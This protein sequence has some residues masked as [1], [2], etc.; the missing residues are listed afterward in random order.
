MNMQDGSH[1]ELND[2]TPDLDDTGAA[3]DVEESPEVRKWLS[4]HGNE[5]TQG[6]EALRRISALE[7][8]NQQLLSLAQ[9][10][11]QEVTPSP[12]RDGLYNQLDAA[13]RQQWDDLLRST[14]L[15]QLSPELQ[16][17]K[18]EVAEGRQFREQVTQ[19]FQQQ[20]QTALEGHVASLRQELGDD[21]DEGMERDIRNA[22]TN[23]GVDVGNRMVELAKQIASGKQ[24][25]RTQ[26]RNSAASF[27][28]TPTRGGRAIPN[29]LKKQSDGTMKYD[30]KQAWEDAERLAAQNRGR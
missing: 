8:Q 19:Y 15:E 29:G 28:G 13:Q 16:Q 11:R 7:Q 21:F 4:K 20:G 5:L 6:R 27:G 17:L 26:Q 24:Q 3:Q 10:N 25:T 18:K 1:E 2:T 22:Y 23:G 14:P 30:K 9:Q 12:S